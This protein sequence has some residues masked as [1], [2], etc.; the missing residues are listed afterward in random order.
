MRVVPFSEENSQIKSR[1]LLKF[2]VFELQVTMRT[3]SWIWCPA[4]VPFYRTR[5]TFNDLC[6]CIR[7]SFLPRIT[8]TRIA[9]AT[10]APLMWQNFLT[11]SSKDKVSYCDSN[12]WTFSKFLDTMKDQSSLEML[13]RAVFLHVIF[14]GRIRILATISECMFSISSLCI[15]NGNLLFTD[16]FGKMFMGSQ[17]D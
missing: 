4:C 10:I 5:A 6:V 15:S 7:V 12:L 13:T 1:V 14:E 2:L 11:N 17:H 3:F 16:S 9:R 8:R